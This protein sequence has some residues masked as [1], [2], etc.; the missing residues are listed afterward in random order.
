M[1]GD[2][3][4]TAAQERVLRFL[5]EEA[6]PPPVERIDTHAAVVLLAGNRAYKMK[7]AVRYSF[8]DFTTLER[9]RRALESELALNRRT[10]PEL[11]LRLLP[12]VRRTDG[13]LALGEEGEVVEWLLEMRRFPQE[14]RL[15]RVAARGALTAGLL[16]ALAG[17]I[18]AFH[19]AAPVRADKGGVAAM[20]GIVAGNAADL[21]SLPPD[22]L[23][24]DA[25]A[26]VTADSEAALATAAP[27][28]ERRR[29][30]GRVRHC[31]GDL[32]LANI[33]LLEGRPVLYDCIE[34]DEDLACI[35]VLYDLAFLVMDLLERGMR[36]EAWR[37]LQTYGDETWEDEGQALMPLFLAVRA[38]I[39][40]KVEGFAARIAGDRAARAAGVAA[41]RAYLDLAA[42][43][44]APVRPRLVAIGGLSGSGKSSVARTLAPEL[45]PAPGAM[46]LRSDVIRKRLFGRRPDERLPPTSYRSEI[47]ARVFATIER[48]AALLLRGG[49]SVVCDGVY[50]DPA[51]RRGIEAVARAAGADFLGVWLEAPPGVL[52]ARVAARRG[53]ASD[54]DVAVLRRQRE[55]VD[56][57]AVAWRRLDAD[58][59]VAEIAAEIHRLLDGP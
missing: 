27:L 6:L 49:R 52:E 56:T 39:R 21:V 8:L 53:D 20:R 42:R 50:G 3:I 55:S 2:A 1:P 57:T 13:K 37:L 19:R 15:D 45:E 40:A 59:P 46:V 18:V 24:A 5:L 23:D 54:A 28:L 22:I 14:A 30:I 36:R 31:H 29:R 4:V 48:R 16:D 47:G 17:E 35:D 12:V 58:R 51:Q 33:V 32:H 10:A 11:Y 25:A 43:V 44:L 9:R 34:F 7:R 41:A 38:T 26:R